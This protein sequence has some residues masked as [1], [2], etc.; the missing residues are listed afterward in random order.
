MSSLH[1]L[2]N[3]TDVQL[4]QSL[5]LLRRLRQSHLDHVRELDKSIAVI[6]EGLQALETDNGGPD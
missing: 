5:S 4:R 6:E 1:D 2:S 3:A